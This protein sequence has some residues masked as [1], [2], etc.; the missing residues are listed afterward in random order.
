MSIYSKVS[1]TPT[2]SPGKTVK[3]SYPKPLSHSDQLAEIFSD[4]EEYK[5]QKEPTANNKIQPIKDK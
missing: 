5:K 1:Q 2:L 3:K 4:E